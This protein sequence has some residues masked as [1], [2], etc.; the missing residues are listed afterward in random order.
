M[1]SAE[2]FVGGC[3]RCLC[4]RATSG[5]RQAAQFDLVEVKCGSVPCMLC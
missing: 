5:A 1:I 2:V 4:W 3:A